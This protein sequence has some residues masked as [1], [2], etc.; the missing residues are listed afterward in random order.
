MATT[1]LNRREA[2]VRMALMMGG[3]MVGPR[4][5]AGAWDADAPGA[6]S[7]ANAGDL[8][9]LDEIGD[10]IIPATDV[11]GAKAVDIGAFITMMLR[12]CYDEKDQAAVRA[13]LIALAADYRTKHGHA[14]VGAPVAERTDFLNALDREQKA[15]S[16]KKKATEPAHYFRVL[17][18]L[19]ILGYFTSEIGATQAL[20]FVEVPGRFDGSAP[21]KKGE[22]AWATS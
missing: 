13:G 7:G 6:A 21:Y 16:K 11:P 18:E 8:A 5:L 1:T 15:Y 12:D 20:R 14:F 22:H 9:L 3:T 4:L 17:K 2:I 10:T 19:T